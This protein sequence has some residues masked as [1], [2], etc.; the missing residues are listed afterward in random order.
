[1]PTAQEIQQA[2]TD[3]IV[4]IMEAGTKDN[5][6]LWKQTL[7]KWGEGGMPFNA[8]TGREYSGVNVLALWMAQ[9]ERGYTSG[10]WC[11]F[12][13]AQ[14]KGWK[15]K[16]GAKGECV[17]F[18]SKVPSRE[19]KDKLIPMLRGYY[20][21]NADSIEGYEAPERNSATLENI[22]GSDIVNDIRERHNISLQH[23]GNNAFYAP[24]LDIVNLPSLASFTSE[25]NYIHVAMHEF[26]HWTGH[27]SRLD[28]LSFNL[29]FG[30]EAYAFEELVAELSAAFTMAM[31][32]RGE[33]QMEHHANYLA[34]WIKVLKNDRTMIFK[35]ASKANAATMYLLAQGGAEE[36][37]E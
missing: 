28:R 22:H 34:S 10:A 3:R 8:I 23:G 36:T 16:K 14:A 1:M 11:T 37:E 20:V 31:L 5:G 4:A 17:I 15:V 32:N 12:K 25:N 6:K 29:R 13:Q 21:F 2:V 27:K 26:A 24:A 19:D 35:A 7:S 30:D 18:Y 33:S 9:A